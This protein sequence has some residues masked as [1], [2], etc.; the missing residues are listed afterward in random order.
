MVDINLLAAGTRCLL[1][2]NIF[3]YHLADASP[4]CSNFIERIGAGDFDAYVTTTIIAEVLH[5]RMM[6]EALATGVITSGQ[7]LKK[8][9][10]DSS[11]IRGLSA[12][13]AEV[14]D[15]LLLPLE[16]VEVALDDIKASHDLRRAHGLFVND[17]INLACAD[18]L[19]VADVVTHDAD[20]RRVPHVRVWEPTDV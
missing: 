14:E 12:Y 5:R 1:D 4:D 3:I 11:L 17:S 6:A 18:R 19:G 16:V 8:L 20:F 7:P 13:I 2:A 9:K 15:L 10:A